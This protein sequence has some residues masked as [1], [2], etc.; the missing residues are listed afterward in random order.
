MER[1]FTVSH[2]LI[3][4]AWVQL[5]DYRVLVHA[6]WQRSTAPGRHLVEGQRP[7]RGGPVR[8]GH[9]EPLDPALPGW[10]TNDNKFRANDG[11]YTEVIHT[12]AGLLGYITNLGHTDF[13]PNGGINMP[14]CNSQQCDHDRCFYYLAESLRTGGFTGTRCATY[15]GAMTGNCVL[16]VWLLTLTLGAALAPAPWYSLRRLLESVQFYDIRKYVTKS[17]NVAYLANRWSYGCHCHPAESRYQRQVENPE[18]SQNFQ[19]PYEQLN[20]C[21]DPADRQ[22]F[23][24]IPGD[25]NCF[26]FSIIKLLDLS[27]TP[28]QIRKQ[29]L[30]SPL[31]STGV[32]GDMNMDAALEAMDVLSQ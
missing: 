15:A 23:K 22:A 32:H 29:L 9:A 26:F 2:M 19:A 25:G 10:I 13:Y 4:R 30:A 16:W 27:I 21:A 11:A 20:N 7:E 8:A 12:N 5:S 17:Y 14:G 1:P 24:D 31:T 3:A 6:C 18:L 28:S